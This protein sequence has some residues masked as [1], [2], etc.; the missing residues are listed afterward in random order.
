MLDNGGIHYTYLAL[1]EGYNVDVYN[2]IYTD[3]SGDVVATSPEVW[4]EVVI[5][6]MLSDYTEK[7]RD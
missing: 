3:P 7:K 4:E 6:E 5:P 1:E 2:S